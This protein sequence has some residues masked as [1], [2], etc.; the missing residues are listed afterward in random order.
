ME[1]FNITQNPEDLIEII[2]LYDRSWN[3]SSTIGSKGPTCDLNREI[4][5]EIVCHESC[6]TCDNFASCDF[7]SCTDD[8]GFAEYIIE[9]I[10][11]QWCVDL[12]QLHFSGISNGGMFAYYVAATATDALGKYQYINTIENFWKLEKQCNHLRKSEAFSY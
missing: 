5:E 1:K 11:E 4:W 10:T 3:C 8:I 2:F 6:P 7:A 12:D 9:E